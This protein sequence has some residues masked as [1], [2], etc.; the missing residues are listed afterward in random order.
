[1]HETPLHLHFFAG[2]RHRMQE[3][4]PLREARHDTCANHAAWLFC[5]PC[6]AELARGCSQTA[7]VNWE[8]MT[9]DVEGIAT[10]TT[11]PGRGSPHGCG[12]DPMGCNSRA[13][14]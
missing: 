10:D 8:A 14:I 7:V 13:M 6:A 12:R 1:M 5:W 3:V 4:T 2:F 9:F 11:A